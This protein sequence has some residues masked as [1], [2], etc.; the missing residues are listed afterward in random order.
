[1]TIPMSF[2]LCLEVISSRSY[3]GKCD[4]TK[5]PDTVSITIQITKIERIVIVLRDNEHSPVCDK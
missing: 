5:P 1:M 2:V 4:K 3:I